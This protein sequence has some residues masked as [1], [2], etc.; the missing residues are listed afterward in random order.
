[1]T[2]NTP[3]EDGGIDLRSRLAGIPRNRL[4]EEVVARWDDVIRLE[5]EIASLRR[6]L[7]EVELVTED[8]VLESSR[9]SQ[10]EERLRVA[11]SKIRKLEGSLVNEKSRRKSIEEDSSRLLELQEENSR[12]LRNEEELLLLVLDMEAEID[13]L[14]K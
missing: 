14:S 4:V 9:I 6:R 1:M 13:R 8:G 3:P 10:M 7:R 12:L 5:G 11:D 2:V